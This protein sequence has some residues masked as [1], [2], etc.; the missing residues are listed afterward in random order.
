M[1]LIKTITHSAI[2]ENFL[3]KRAYNIFAMF[4]KNNDY[5]G[6]SGGCISDQPRISIEIGTGINVKQLA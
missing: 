1:P 4:S 2:F 5:P 6:P 3:T